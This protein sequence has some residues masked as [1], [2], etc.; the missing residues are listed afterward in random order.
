MNE[1]AADPPRLTAPCFIMSC[2][3]EWGSQS[4]RL[5]AAL[6]LLFLS[7]R[8]LTHTQT[9]GG[10]RRRNTLRQKTHTNLVWDGELGL[11]G[12]PGRVYGCER[13]GPRMGH[14]LDKH[15]HLK[16]ALHGGVGAGN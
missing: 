3:E 1:Q 6:R 11:I 4:Q 14:L 16:T 2:R 9:E 7:H 8:S 13:R 5:S 12:L 10:G 15:N